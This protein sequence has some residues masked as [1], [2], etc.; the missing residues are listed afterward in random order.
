MVMTA[1]FVVITDAVK[2]LEEVWMVLV[3][4]L[5]PL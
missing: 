3:G 4:V 5:L 1:V 2:I